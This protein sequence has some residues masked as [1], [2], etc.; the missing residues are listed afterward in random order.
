MSGAASEK[1]LCNE[2]SDVVIGYVL[3]EDVSWL[4]V[5]AVSGVVVDAVRG[6]QFPTDNVLVSGAAVPVFDALAAVPPGC[7]VHN[8]R[9]AL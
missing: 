5:E 8:N 2:A 4:V 9:N 3:R 1:V 6:L 7:T